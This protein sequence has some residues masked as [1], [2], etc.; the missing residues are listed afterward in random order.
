MIC[1]LFSFLEK[2]YCREYSQKYKYN[3]GSN[4]TESSRLTPNNIHLCLLRVFSVFMWFLFPT[5]SHI[6]AEAFETEIRADGNP[7]V[8]DR[9]I[10]RSHA[11]IQRRQV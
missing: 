6:Q 10:T 9:F 4:R 7:K 1:R 8:K 11:Q 3:T 5:C 2:R